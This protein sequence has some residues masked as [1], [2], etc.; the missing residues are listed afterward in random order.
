MAALASAAHEETAH[1][2]AHK[3]IACIISSCKPHLWLCTNTID[4]I[5]Y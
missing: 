5:D 3:H 4:T 2:A 1:M